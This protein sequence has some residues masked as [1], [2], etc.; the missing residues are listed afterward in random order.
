[1]STRRRTAPAIDKSQSTLAFHG[2]LSKITKPSNTTPSNK[3]VDEA[4]ASSEI[5]SDKRKGPKSAALPNRNDDAAVVVPTTGDV[6]TEDAHLDLHVNE[7]KYESESED[8]GDEAREQAEMAA[9]RKV[10][11]NARKMSQ[12]HIKSYWKRKEDSRKA[13]RVHQKDLTIHESILREWDMTGHFGVSDTA[14]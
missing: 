7:E 1:M 4:K 12:K 11:E 8:E 6:V 10:A 3:P 9:L 5:A 13:P 14:T 2:R